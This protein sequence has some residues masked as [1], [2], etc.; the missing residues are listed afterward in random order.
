MVDLLSRNKKISIITLCTV[1]FRS[2]FEKNV[3]LGLPLSFAHAE[4][5]SLPHYRLSLRWREALIHHRIQYD[6]LIIAWSKRPSPRFMNKSPSKLS[7]GLIPEP[8][9][10]SYYL[11]S[12]RRWVIL[13]A[14]FV[15][16][17]YG[18]E[19][20]RGMCAEKRDTSICA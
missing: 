17:M 9:R 1:G 14:A 19:S 15:V 16:W 20:E 2:A 13:L 7:S 8:E 4:L 11:L 6:R 12:S 3:P 18:G 5:L 10:S